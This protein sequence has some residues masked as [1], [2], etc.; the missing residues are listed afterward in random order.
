MCLDASTL[1]NLIAFAALLVTGIY[2]YLTGRI[3]DSS[4]S[5]ANEQIRPFVVMSMPLDGES[6]RI[7]L[8]IKNVGVRPA[9]DVRI[10]CVP[11]PQELLKWSRGG[12]DISRMLEQPM[13]A[14]NQE[15]RAYL[16]ETFYVLEKGTSYP[17]HFDVSI[18]YRD[19]N[20][21]PYD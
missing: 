4:R 17:T 19:S 12:F 21:N 6:T 13:I 18:R 14:P 1:T 15:F 7:I 2:V 16:C 20:D 10:K 5:F 11:S 8:S 3:L 9:L